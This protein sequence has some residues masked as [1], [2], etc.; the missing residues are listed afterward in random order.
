MRLPISGDLESIQEQLNV[1]EQPQG[2]PLLV[3]GS[4]G[5]GKTALTVRRVQMMAE[6]NIGLIVLSGM[7][8]T[9]PVFADDDHALSQI[10]A[11]H[12]SRYCLTPAFNDAL[13]GPQVLEHA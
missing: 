7:S 6:A 5:F 11:R 2:E 4:P 9:I 10:N 12:L 3:A 8:G 13:P 1:L